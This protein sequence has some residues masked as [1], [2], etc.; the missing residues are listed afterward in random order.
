MYSRA[1]RVGNRL[2][3]EES[4]VNSWVELHKDA[5]MKRLAAKANRKVRA[6]DDSALD[7]SLERLIGSDELM[8][9]GAGIDV[10]RHHSWCIDMTC[11]GCLA[12]GW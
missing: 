5:V 4:I 2:A 10:V 3:L 6:L 12:Q 8:E 1:R 7:E 9:L 11:R